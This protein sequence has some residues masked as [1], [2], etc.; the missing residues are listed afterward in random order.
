MTQKSRYNL[1]KKK[2]TQ[3]WISFLKICFKMTNLKP[4]GLLLFLQYVCNSFLCAAFETWKKKKKEII[5]M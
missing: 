5:F 1:H 3:Q 2:T 4:T